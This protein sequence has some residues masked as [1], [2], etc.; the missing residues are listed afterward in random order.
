MTRYLRKKWHQISPFS[1]WLLP[2]AFF[3]CIGI[4]LFVSAA[5]SDSDGMSDEYENFFGLNPTNAADASENNDGDTL[6]NLEEYQLWTDPFSGDTDRDG[7]NDNA[8]S[9]AISRVYIDWG[10]SAFTS[11]DY[12]EYAAPN[13]W[14]SAYKDAGTW[15]TSPA[16]WYVAASE[17]NNIGT[18]SIDFDRSLLTNDVV[19]D[20][21]LFDSTNAFLYID[22]YDTNDIIVATNL[23][24][25][26][27]SGSNTTV[28][29]SYEIPLE[30]YAA[31][32]GIELR[33]QSGEIKVFESVVFVDKDGDGLDKEQEAQ[34]GTSDNDADSD[35]DG[36]NDYAEVFA[37][38]TDPAVSDSDGDGLSDGDEVNTYGTDPNDT[39]S[40]NDG[41]SDGMEV[42]FGFQPAGS[43]T[44]AALPF[45]ENFETNT[46][47]VGDL[48]GQNGWTASP[49]N[50]A[51]V[52][53]GKVYAGSQALETWTTNA[54]ISVRQYFTAPDASVIWGDFYAQ[55][56][57]RPAWTTDP[58]STV[59]FHFST[60]RQ[61]VVFDGD[62]GAG[63][64]WVTIT[65]HAALA[66]ETW[67]RLTVKIDYGT[68]K[69]ILC[70]DGLKVA[71]NLGFSQARTEFSAFGVDSRWSYVDGLSISTG[72]PTGVSFDDDIL[73]DAWELSYFGDL[74]EGEAGDSDGD[75]LTNLEEYQGGLDPTDT[76]SDGDGV[77]D[78][79]E[80]EWG[81]AA[82]NADSYATIPW[83]TDFESG[84]GYSA[85]NLAGQNGWIVSDGTASVQTNTVFSNS[86]AV[87]F[88]TNLSAGIT[89]AKLFASVT[90]TV[91]WSEFRLLSDAGTLPAS[92]PDH[93]A[94][95]FAINTSGFW[96]ARSGASW[97]SATNTAISTNTW[98]HISVKEDF[99]SRTWEFYVGQDPVWQGLSFADTNSDHYVQFAVFGGSHSGIYLDSA[100]VGTSA[101][102]HI[103]MDGDGLT[104]AEEAGLGT[105]PEKADTDND[106]MNDKTEIDQGYSPTSSN[107]FF[108]M[109]TGSGTNI[110]NTGFESGEGYTTNALN[111]QKSWVASND[112]TV[113]DTESN[114][115]T[116][117]VLIPADNST[118]G[119]VNAMVAN[120]G[121]HGRDDV[122][123][124]FYS[125]FTQGAVE[126]IE[127]QNAAGAFYIF[128]DKVCAYD[129]VS[130]AWK[131]SAPTFTVG[132]GEWTRVDVHADYVAREYE[133]AVNGALAVDEV[134]FDPSVGDRF[135]RFKVQGGTSLGTNDTFI[136]DIRI[137]SS[138]PTGLDYDSDGL[139]NLDEYQYGTDHKDADTDDDGLT[140]YQEIITYGTDPFNADGDGDGIPDPGEIAMGLDPNDGAD[141]ALDPDSD[142][143]TNLEEYQNSTDHTDADSD[144]DG[145]NDGVEVNT[146]GT[147]PN[148]ADT[149]GD[150]LPDKWEVDNGTDPL[151]NDAA[152]DPDNDRLTN[153]EEYQLGTDPL[154]ADTDDDGVDDYLEVTQS[155]TDPLVV[156]FDG[157]ATNSVT[158]TTVDTVYGNDTT[159]MVGTWT[160]EGTMIYAR[161]RSGYV[162]YVLTAPT[163]GNYAVSVDIT[164][165]NWLTTKTQFDLSLY[166]DGALSGRQVADAPYGT[167]FTATFFTPTILAGEHTAKLWWRNLAG[168]TFLQINEIRL[169]TYG[170]VDTN[171]NGI[172]DW[173]ER[174]LAVMSDQ[175]VPPETSIVSPICLEGESYYQDLL[176]VTA[177]YVPEGQT[178]QV[179]TVKHGAGNDWYANVFISPTN[180]TIIEVSDQNDA[181][182]YSN[183]V[184]WSAMNIMDDAYTNG[185]TIRKNDSLLLTAYPTNETNGAVTIEILLGTNVITNVV[186][187]VDAPV[188]HLFDVAGDYTVSGTFSNAT[189][190]TNGSVTVSI[191]Y[192]AFA[193]EEV[194][195]VK[196]VTRSWLCTNLPNETVIE[197]DSDLTVTATN[198]VGGGLGFTILAQDDVTR[199]MVARLPA[200]SGVDGGTNSLIMD[201]VKVSPIY[202]DDGTYW[203]VVA[204][205]PDGS[206]M[207]E[208]SAAIGYVPAD[209]ELR[210]SISVGGAMFENGTLQM[211]LTA[212]DFN[213]AGVATYRMIQP[214]GS[215]GSTCHMTYIYQG[216][217]YIGK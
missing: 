165:H 141:G 63:G 216:D 159:N 80:L 72:M 56:I 206:R 59:A 158:I 189:V 183:T 70:L 79:T 153:T 174:R 179:I 82:T 42:H 155:Y 36:L 150:G 62:A 9:T 13:W 214:V 131:F 48:N 188:E 55:V 143:L 50:I 168:N 116:Q 201:N 12:H 180:D 202:G 105:D 138:E 29:V 123:V 32:V 61:L 20:L 121:A 25:N 47:S 199:Y 27:L 170:G 111:G 39:D 76:D 18:L 129:G 60:N 198:L 151:V 130:N 23:F 157:T 204:T 85:G 66:S 45:T 160:K 93:T 162:E 96:N 92:L 134:G 140:D 106:G 191:L 117:S 94:G 101:P 83:S 99:S 127:D 128:A 186:T 211:T 54:E 97:V 102:G 181:V 187:S 126:G 1:K 103:D 215:N 133:I 38:N 114:N 108:R 212:S 148:N 145:L 95:A 15:Q 67:V 89:S 78:F 125:K 112:V 28:N 164:Q 90:N 19:L 33:R 75:G 44:Y 43:N 77:D 14:V 193:L 84:A 120:V 147:N 167:V 137:S 98:V 6:T 119:T 21:Q 51:L 64:E 209:I 200:L 37:H 210:L 35:D 213:E 65:N 3:L 53:T 192:G 149:D 22:L 7:W 86:Q 40:D 166:I 217:E 176:A 172:A 169:E 152:G 81:Q 4:A 190:T 173:E 135:S 142:G 24:G 208:I 110:W 109:D 74:D 171:S 58:D 178:Q 194:V 88:S 5:D 31:A 34:L 69:W 124:T 113:V 136:D 8:D 122:W 156:E 196:T 132:T 46:V 68:A 104:N 41:M 182:T 139:S 73:P 115:G 184:T 57:A 2:I 100:S 17:S 185:T 154:D 146:H 118:N 195:C 175:D 11:N 203:R 26:I 177:S 163:S 52:Q 107:S 91:I 16:A 71:G 87:V 10:N 30:T 161:E 207:V 49:T 197:Y 144:D 205:Y